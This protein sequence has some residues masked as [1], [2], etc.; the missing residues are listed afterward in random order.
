MQFCLNVFNLFKM[1]K[2][3]QSVCSSYIYSPKICNQPTIYLLLVLHKRTDQSALTIKRD[4][5]VPLYKSS[6]FNYKYTC[7]WQRY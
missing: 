2:A 5:K 6:N 4:M 1:T 7:I 3:T